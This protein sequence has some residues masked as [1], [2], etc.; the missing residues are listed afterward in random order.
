MRLSVTSRSHRPP[1]MR[2]SVTSPAQNALFREGPYTK[3]AFPWH[4]R[5]RMHFSVTSPAQ[6]ALF[7]RV[8]FSSPAQTWSHLTQRRIL[9]RRS[10]VKAQSVPATSRKG[11]LYTLDLTE[12]RT[13]WPAHTQ[14]ALFRDVARPE[15]AF[16]WRRRHRM[17]FSVEC[18]F[19]HLRKRRPASRKS[20]FWPWDLTQRRIL[21]PAPHGKPHSGY[22]PSR[23]SALY[24]IDTIRNAPFG[25][26]A[27]AECAFPY[28][29]GCRM[30]F[31][32][33]C[34]FPHLRKRR[35]TS[36]KSAL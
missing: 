9:G 35:P 4:R 27:T 11:A 31:S 16:P 7:R 26:V 1:R 17:R 5:H 24:V 18:A 14:N 20:A 10:H 36:R 30:R 19:P 34:A 23:K 3:C 8:R 12:K 29:T 32:V 21:T 6:S 15:C 33:E 25:N 2:L 22:G 13:L 28:S